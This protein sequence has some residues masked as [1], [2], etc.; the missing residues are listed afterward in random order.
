MSKTDPAQEQNQAEAE[1]K[2]RKKAR[3]LVDCSIEGK[4]YKVNDVLVAA[5]EIVAAA[6]REGLVDSNKAAVAYAEALKG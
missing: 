6:E 5:P 2:K 3:V 1:G 4:P